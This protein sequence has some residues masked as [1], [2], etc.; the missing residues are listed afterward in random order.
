MVSTCG[1]NAEPSA[2][3]KKPASATPATSATA[4]PAAVYSFGNRKHDGVEPR[5]SLTADGAIVYGRTTATVK[6]VTGKNPT[7]VIFSY[8]TSSGHFLTIH[9]FAGA[10]KDGAD[11][12][13][14]AMT[15]FNGFMIGTTENGGS[16]TAKSCGGSIGC[17]TIFAFDPS[18]AKDTYC[19]VHNFAGLGSI[20]PDGAQPHSNYAYDTT[21]GVLWGMT[22]EGGANNQGTIYSLTPGTSSLCDSAVN[23][24]YSFAKATGDDSHGRLTLSAD[25]Q[26]LYGMTRKGGTTDKGNPT[27]Y[28]VVFE[29]VI[30]TGQY[31]VLHD[32]EGCSKNDGAQTDHGYLTL[33]GNVLYGMTTFGG[34]HGCGKSSSSNPAGDGILFG[35]EPG[36]PPAQGQACPDPKDLNYQ[37]IW[38]FSGSNGKNPYGSLLQEGDNLY[39]TTA[40]GGACGKGT[41]FD[42]TLDSGNPM[43]AADYAILHSFCGAPDGAKP[44]DNVILLGSTLYGMTSEG[45]ANSAVKHGNG[46]IFAINLPPD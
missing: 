39:G 12:R 27:N 10:T 20:P 43:Q 28:G 13:H 15:P 17:G 38:D 26:V 34:T 18:N 25:N 45:G 31:C 2:G 33:S 37:I 16:G 3:G 35:I 29:Y 46:S 19:V 4:T 8:D 5:G 23:V 32:F 36:A 22:A 9:E 14:D 21:R 11:P 24:V 41:A 30:A 44:V 1:A 40:G 7:G 42:L 6:T